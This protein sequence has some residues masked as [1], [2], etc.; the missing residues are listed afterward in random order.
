MYVKTVLRSSLDAGKW[1]ERY[2]GV[3]LKEYCP[4]VTLPV[5]P[6]PEKTKIRIKKGVLEVIVYK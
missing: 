4:V 6:R 5:E 3:E 1:S 2:R